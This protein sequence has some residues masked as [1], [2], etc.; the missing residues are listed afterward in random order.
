MTRVALRDIHRSRVYRAE[1]R[2]WNLLDDADHTGERTV[3]LF[4]TRICLPVEKRMPDI[5]AVAAYLDG[6]LAL[7]AVRR[8]YSRAGLPLTVRARRGARA[9]GHY[10]PTTAT[11][12]ISMHDP[13]A[14]RELLLLH[15]LAHHLQPPVSTGHGPEFCRAY[16]DLIHNVMTPETAWL[17][18][19]CLTSEGARCR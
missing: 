5:D 13:H 2:L 6:V 9:H 17:L 10:E 8:R 1:Q 19:A 11:I 4:G 3:E 18:R 15:E 12:A 14:V 16:S 7:R